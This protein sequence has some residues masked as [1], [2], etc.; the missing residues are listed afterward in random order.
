ME[1]EST[2]LRDDEILDEFEDEMSIAGDA[3]TDDT[4][5]DTSDDSDGDGD[6]DADDA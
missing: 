4:D 2:T 1:T 3:D 6:A 5:G